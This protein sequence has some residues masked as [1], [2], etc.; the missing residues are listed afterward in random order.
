M[1]RN[2]A[3][4]IFGHRVC[5]LLDESDD[6]RERY[7]SDSRCYPAANTTLASYHTRRPSVHTD[8]APPRLAHETRAMPHPGPLALVHISYVSTPFIHNRYTGA[9]RGMA[10]LTRARRFFLWFPCFASNGVLE[11]HGMNGRPFRRAGKNLFL[12]QAPG[13]KGWK[14]GIRRDA[15]PME[16]GYAHHTPFH[17]AYLDEAARGATKKSPSPGE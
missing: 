15:S 3:D 9:Y 12:L 14:S 4:L 17:A 1:E 11:D 5:L 7:T 13:K 2:G 10:R 8:P 16:V 6:T